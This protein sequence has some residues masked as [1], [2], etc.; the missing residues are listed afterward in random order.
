MLYVGRDPS[1]PAIG[2]M[3]ISFSEVPL[4]NASVVAAQAGSGFAPFPTN[5]G[6]TVELISPG[7]VDAKIMFQHAQE[8]NVTMTWMLRLIGVVFML[9]GFSLDAAAARRRGQRH[10]AAGRRDRRRHV[11]GGA[12]L[13]NGRSR[14]S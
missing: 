9:V 3:R 12:G 4:Q 1:Q 10:P 14:P 2:D 7:I 6:T 13:H 8:E 11:P 5:T